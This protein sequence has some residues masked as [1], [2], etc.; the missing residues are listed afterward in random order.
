MVTN[1][2]ILASIWITPLNIEFWP[3]LF[4]AQIV[5][6]SFTLISALL[7][8]LFSVARETATYILDLVGVK[9]VRCDR[10]GT[11]PPGD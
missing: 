9:E 4:Y 2:V 11:E 5:L 1:S 7:T 8:I 6:T 3:A 10:G